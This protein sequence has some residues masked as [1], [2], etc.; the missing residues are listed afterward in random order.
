MQY[1]G[2]LD[3]SIYRCVSEDISTDEV[4][5]TDERI[6]HIIQRRGEDFFQKYSPMFPQ[7]ISDPDYIFPDEHENSAL[8]CKTFEDG[9][10]SINLVL[11]IAVESDASHYKNSIITAVRENKKRFAQRV[12]NSEILFKKIDNPG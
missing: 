5:I 4:I 10:T 7:V 8:V 1:V 6:E 11:R 3:K 2:K 9:N 12:R